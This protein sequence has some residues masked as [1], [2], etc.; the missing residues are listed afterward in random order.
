[1]L[2]GPLYIYNIFHYKSLE[3]IFNIIDWFIIF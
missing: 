1:M 2:L 3:Y